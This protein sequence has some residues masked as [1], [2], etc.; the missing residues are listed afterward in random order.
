[1]GGGTGVGKET[2]SIVGLFGGDGHLTSAALEA[3]HNGN[4][5]DDPLILALEH[6]GGCEA[7]ADALA[8]SFD[9]TELIQVPT[10]FEEELQNRLRTNKKS[11]HAFAFYVLKVAIAAVIALIIT[12]SSAFGVIV[13]NQDKTT[14]IKAPSFSFV[15]AISEQLSIFSQNVVN[16]EVFNYAQTEK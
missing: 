11:S 6:S 16:M 10:G 3:L 2:I 9:D 13:K 1:M 15:N 4:L 7:C 5:C 8:S 14:Q 12:Y